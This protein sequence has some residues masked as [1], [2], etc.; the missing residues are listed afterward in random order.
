MC[1]SL[2]IRVLEHVEY[3]S[4]MTAASKDN[5]EVDRRVFWAALGDSAVVGDF[6][7]NEY[8]LRVES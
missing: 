6:E 4:R 8:D 1:K 3:F 2:H 7:R 5:Q